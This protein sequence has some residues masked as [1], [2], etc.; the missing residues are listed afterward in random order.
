MFCFVVWL[1]LCYADTTDVVNPVLLLLDVQNELVEIQCSFL[2]NSRA[3]GCLVSISTD[4]GMYIKF[5]SVTRVGSAAVARTMLPKGWRNGY[6]V[7]VL[8]WEEDRSKGK[9]N[10]PVRTVRQRLITVTDIVSGAT[11]DS[12][13]MI[14]MYIE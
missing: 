8:D 10:I 13:L 6:N 11:T 3:L 7:T 1:F 14:L 4:N 5:L 2:K 12:G 9:L